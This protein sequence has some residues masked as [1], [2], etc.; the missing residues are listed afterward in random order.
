MKN[1]EIP[2]E[3]L[4]FTHKNYFGVVLLWYD[5]LH[6]KQLQYNATASF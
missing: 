4:G 6:N 1:N 5:L 3:N 2:A